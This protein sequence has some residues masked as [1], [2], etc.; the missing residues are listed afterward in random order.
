ME[1]GVMSQPSEKLIQWR[2]SPG[3]YKLYLEYGLAAFDADPYS[4]EYHLAL[5]N[6]KSLP[7]Y[8]L[9]YDPQG[10]ET[11]FP[12]VWHEELGVVN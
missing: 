5:D 4:D 2:M 8:P 9:D 10:N 1:G 6:L 3:T 12:V 7:G 11:L